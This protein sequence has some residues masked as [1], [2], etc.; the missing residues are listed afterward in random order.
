MKTRNASATIRFGAM[1]SD[2]T[3]RKGNVSE[4]IPLP[5]AEPGWRFNE[6]RDRKLNAYKS[7]VASAVCE[8][9]GI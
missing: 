7:K 5:V 9:V 1:N 8:I 6:R 3:V 4:V 2:V